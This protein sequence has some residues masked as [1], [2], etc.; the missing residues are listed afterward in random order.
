MLTNEIFGG[1]DVSQA[2][3]DYALRPTGRAGQVRN[4]EVGIAALV[5]LLKGSS[6][7]LVV[8]EA[9][10]GL[11]RP[12]VTALSAAQI[13][14][15]VVN[16][17]RARAFA[18]AIG[19][20]AKTDR[21]DAAGL[22]ELG[23]RLRPEARPLP[24]TA[25]QELAALVTRRQQLVAQHTAEQNRL[26]TALPVVRESLQQHLTWLE[27]VIAE[28][29]T[30]IADRIEAHPQWRETAAIVD[31]APGIG[32]HTAS[33][34]VASLPELGQLGGKQIAALVGVAPL[35]RDSGK[36]QGQRHIKA[37]RGQ[38]RAVLYMAT[39]AA[40]R[41]NPTIKA[42]YQRLLKAGKLK[43]VAL[44]ACMRKLLTILNAMVKHGSMWENKTA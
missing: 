11:E 4:D 25:A 16:P 24:D 26:K 19:L 12:V 29:E 2:T 43:K 36:K 20:L 23:E 35:A 40:T 39:L 34:L 32:P 31:S 6:P 7:T 27:Q 9:T 41:F 22:A 42:F 10:G 1:I 28:L 14:V 15:A 17:R 8:V 18:E 38:I 44:T 21:V 30:E 33:V 5:A 13:P 3:L 37:G